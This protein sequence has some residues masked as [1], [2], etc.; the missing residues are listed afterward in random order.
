MRSITAIVCAW[1]VRGLSSVCAIW[2]NTS[3][4]NGDP[5]SIIMTVGR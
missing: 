3:N 5:S 4:L 2:L 1:L